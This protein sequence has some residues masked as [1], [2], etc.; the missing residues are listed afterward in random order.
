MSKFLQNKVADGD[1]VN[2]RALRAVQSFLRKAEKLTC[3]DQR[4]R[5]DDWDQFFNQN[6]QKRNEE[7]RQSSRYVCK[8]PVKP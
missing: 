7:N 1:N 6:H 3:K 2:S 8:R 4:F 5:Y